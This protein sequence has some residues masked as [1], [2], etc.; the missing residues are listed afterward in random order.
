[1]NNS[2]RTAFAAV[3][4]A[5]TVALSASALTRLDVGTYN[6]RNNHN[7]D[8]KHGNG[9]DVRKS[10]CA[11]LIQYH[12]F[13]IFGTQ[14]CY[15][16]QLEDLKSLMP[17][18]QYIGVGR[19]DGKQEGEYSAIFYRTD[20]FD[21]VDSGNFWLSET[22]DKPTFGWDAACIRIC[23]WAHFRCKDTG[24]EFLFFNLHM[25]HVGKVA[26]VES[27][28]LVQQK[29]QEFGSELPAILTGDFNIDQ[30]HPSFKE[31]IASG[32]LKDSYE[33]AEMRY[34]LNGTFNAFRPD[35]FSQSRIDHVL[36]A[37]S[38]TVK[39]YGILTDTYRSERPEA[40][41][42]TEANAPQEIRFRRYDARTPSDHFPVKVVLYHE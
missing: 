37:P 35:N 33:A 34:A 31:I 9:W 42:T 1:M 2:I 25:D 26:R 15:V 20:K 29:M 39:K 21:V 14:E 27:A 24:F 17:G 13:D 23:T 5:L 4:M 36:V 6:L 22:P 28:K 32:T 40:Q 41:E 8:A 38:F 19:D 10:V 12:E 16:D 30:N 3:V 11:Q 18:Y 7:D